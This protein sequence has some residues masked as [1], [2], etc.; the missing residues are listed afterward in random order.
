MFE[1][2][3]EPAPAELAPLGAVVEIRELSYGE[4]RAQMAASSEPG[5]AAER[6]L[7]AS[8]F[9]DGVPYGFDALRALPGRF[10]GAIADALVQTMRVHGLERATT[11][12][13]LEG[14]C[15]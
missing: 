2:H 5:Q 8:L 10:S 11:P 4:M 14:G 13:R 3:I 15:R 6:L 1:L 12:R 9:V 7:G